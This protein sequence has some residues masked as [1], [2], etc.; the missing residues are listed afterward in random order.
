M[1]GRAQ[2]CVSHTLV[3]ALALGLAGIVRRVLLSHE[4]GVP[5]AATQ[6]ATL[7]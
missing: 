5:P 1:S 4:D 7:P 3:C 6:L 2:V